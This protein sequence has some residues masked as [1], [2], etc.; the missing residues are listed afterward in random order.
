MSQNVHKWHWIRYLDIRPYPIVL[1]R[2]IDDFNDPYYRR[3]CNA[4]RLWMS[5][6]DGIPF[7]KFLAGIYPED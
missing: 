7:S 2:D 5:A 1:N 3:F 6:Y 4:R